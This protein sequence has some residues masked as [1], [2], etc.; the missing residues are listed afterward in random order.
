MK[1]KINQKS[2]SFLKDEEDCLDPPLGH[3]ITYIMGPN[4]RTGVKTRRVSCE[5]DFSTDFFLLI[6][7]C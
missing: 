6:L 3:E 4:R 7:A 1:T 5:R 2:T